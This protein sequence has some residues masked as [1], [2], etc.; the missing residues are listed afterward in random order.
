MCEMGIMIVSASLDYWGD[1]LEDDAPKG[2]GH[3][4]ELSKGALSGS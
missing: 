3:S 4:V 2:F 1:Y